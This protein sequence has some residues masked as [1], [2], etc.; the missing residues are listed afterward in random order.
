[1]DLS[2]EEIEAM[3]AKIG[4]PWH[5]GWEQKDREL[6]AAMRQAGFSNSQIGEWFG[7]SKSTVKRSL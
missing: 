2:A 3:K 5:R 4:K 7:V 1:M 6:A